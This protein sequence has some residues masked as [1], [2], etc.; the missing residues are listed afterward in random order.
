MHTK[1]SLERNFRAKNV[2]VIYNGIDT[3]LFAPK[4]VVVPARF[5]GKTRLLFVGNLIKRKGA[6]LLPLIMERLGNDYVLF[7][8]ECLKSK[9]AFKKTQI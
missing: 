9:A 7:Y 1:N 5:A 8:T 4:R 3:Q 2:E 6:D